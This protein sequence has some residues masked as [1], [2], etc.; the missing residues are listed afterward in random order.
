MPMLPGPLC[1]LSH[2]CACW[3]LFPRPLSVLHF[4]PT[5]SKTREGVVQGVASGTSPALPTCS[6]T[7][8]QG[9][10]TSSE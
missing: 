4:V 8:A 10:P 1:P 5:G 6:L 9:L 3:F 2:H 7:L